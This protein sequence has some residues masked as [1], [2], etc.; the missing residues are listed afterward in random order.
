MLTPC[1]DVQRRDWGE[2][3]AI[4]G[5]RVTGPPG[6]ESLGRGLVSRRVLFE[7]LSAAGHG[8]VAL[9]CGAAGSGKSVLVRSWVEGEGP[10]RTAWVSVE[11]GERDAQRFWLSVIDA[12][13][14][15]VDAVEPPG[16]SPS[17]RGDMLVDRL[18]SGLGS[19]EEPVVLVID[20]VHELD[21]ADALAWLELFLTRLPSQL[22]VVLVTREEP[23]LGLHRLRLAGELTELRD[24]DLRFSVD[25][26]RA[27]LGAAGIELSDA[28]PGIAVRANRGVGGRAAPGG[29]LTGPAS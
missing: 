3:Q 14:G 7:R 25:E 1:V 6:V 2:L 4:E 22:L 9:V 8:G 17:F 12:L 16:P 23:R 11:R 18:L 21:S 5:Y 29:D 15:A 19:L 26:A 28:A 24:P 13:A 27:L 10:G 20:D